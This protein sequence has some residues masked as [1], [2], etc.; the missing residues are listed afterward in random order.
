MTAAKMAGPAERMFCALTAMMPAMTRVM[1]RAEASGRKGM[2]LSTRPRWKW[3]SSRPSSTGTSTILTMDQK[4]PPMSTGTHTPPSS[5]VSGGVS[6]SETRVA[7]AV[8]ATE[9]ATSPR[10]MKV[11]TLEAVPPGAVPTRIMPMAS[12]GGRANT[13]HRAKASS[14]IQPNCTTSPSPRSRGCRSTWLKSC[15]C[16]VMPMPSMMMPSMV[17]ICGATQE[18]IQGCHR[19]SAEKAMMMTPMKRVRTTLSLRRTDSIRPPPLR[20]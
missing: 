17:E 4:R 15:Q 19:A 20:T 18:K 2:S 14:G 7:A 11:S 8:M 16:R 13:W 1:T 6:S 10:A 5:Q 9:K 12:S 3:C